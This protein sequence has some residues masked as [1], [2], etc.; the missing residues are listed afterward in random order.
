[1]HH[2]SPPPLHPIPNRIAHWSLDPEVIFLNHGSFGACP[3]VVL[4]E[5]RKLQDQMEREPVHFLARTLEASLDRVREQMAE[6]VGAFARDLVFVRNATEGVNAVV[7]SLAL[8]P[9]DELLCT[10]HGYN[11]CNNVLRFVAAKAKAKVVVADIPF[12]TES[13]QV[14]I[15]AIEQALTPRTRFVLIDHVTSPTGLIL[16]V[17]SLVRRLRDRGILVMIDGAHAPGMLPLQLNELGADFYTGNAHKWLC[18]PKGAA[19]LHVRH[20]HQSTVRPVVIS[21]GA[22]DPRRHRS[23]FHIE[24][25]W[26]GTFDPSA[27]LALPASLA[28]MRSLAPGGLDEVNAH[29]HQLVV[30]ARDLLCKQLNLTPSA[31][32]SMLGSLATIQLPKANTPTGMDSPLPFDPL[33]LQLFEGYG[34]EVPVFVYNG[35]RCLRVAAQWYNHIAQYQVLADALTELL[36]RG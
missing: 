7:Q 32:E 19:I 20:E 36:A 8:E 24:F 23:R 4:A 14:V 22:N 10:S 15:D 26:T 25:D 35:T 1:M 11:A 17:E 2:R 21:H 12:A 6:F 18:A 28:F 29:N 5:Q 27:I 9:G 33:H 13:A 31:P 16:P 30:Q 3:H 34:I